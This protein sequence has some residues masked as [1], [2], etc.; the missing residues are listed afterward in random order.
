MLPVKFEKSRKRLSDEWKE[1]EERLKAIERQARTIGRLILDVEAKEECIRMAE[2]GIFLE[3]SSLSSVRPFDA[4]PALQ[5][6]AAIR[7]KLPSFL[8]SPLRD[9]YEERCDELALDLE[10][11]QA[12]GQARKIRPLVAR[13]YGSGREKFASRSLVEW[14]ERILDAFRGK[15]QDPTIDHL[16]LARAIRAIAQRLGLSVD[17]KVTQALSASAAYGEKRVWIQKRKFGLCEARRI[18]AHEVFG[19]LLSEENALRQKVGLFE[20][21]TKSAFRDQEGIAIWWE[22][23]TNAIDGHRVQALASRTIATAMLHEGAQFSEVLR[24]LVEKWGIEVRLAVTSTERAFRG[25]GFARDSAYLLGW[26]RVRHAL[27]R[28]KLKPEELQAGRLS[29]EAIPL[30]HGILR[31]GKAIEPGLANKLLDQVGLSG[32]NK[33]NVEF[34][35]KLHE[36]GLACDGSNP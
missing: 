21:G 19:H 29:L 23:K 31:L 18:V 8:S 26:L 9:L 35:A 24:I 17:V 4:S 11:A 36:I 7:K 27:A 14:A 6:L 25:G 5:D 12:L 3:P 20:I 15:E 16:D 34:H 13:R 1:L 2:R 33:K 30:L 28:G 32:C 22:E 10:I